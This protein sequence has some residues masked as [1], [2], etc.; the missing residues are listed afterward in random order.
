MKPPWWKSAV[1]YQIY[2]R[3][4]ADAS[5]DGIGDLGGVRERLDHLAWLGVDALW[6]SPIYPSPMADFGYDVA[7]YC[8]VHPLFGSLAEFDAL[9]AAAHARGI[10]VLL[11]FVGAH[12]SH[13]HP[14][15]RESR[16]SRTSPKRGWYVWRDA[17]PDGSLP[18]NWRAAF[19]ELPAWTLDEKTGQYYL[20]SFLPEQPDLDWSN[21]E[22]VGAMHGALRFWLDRGVDGFR[23][24]VIHNIGK[25]PALPDVPPERERLPHHLL[26]DDPL[27]LELLRRMRRLLDSYPGERV[28]V[29]EVVLLSTQAIARH[30]GLRDGLH[31]AFNFLPLFAPWDAA[32]WRKRIES[33]SLELDP[34]DAW[35]TWVLSNH[36]N[37]RHATRY[38]SEARARASAFLLLGLRGTPF[39]YQGEELGL[40][41]AAIPESRRVDPG[42]RDGCRA[43]LP[44]DGKPPLHGWPADPWLPFPPDA[45]R[46][47]VQSLRSDPSSIL[48]LYRRLLSARR[49]SPA[50]SVGAQTLL[51]APDGVVAWRRELEGDVRWVAVNFTGEERKIFLERVCSVEVASD[52]AGEGEV[53]SGSLRPDQALLLRR[54]RS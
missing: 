8:D 9:V 52:G 7:D 27:T 26:N 44:W 32:Q 19:L 47:N 12:T 34:I 28:M 39:L 23:A 4:F 41:D 38:G 48:H 46:R 49:A 53:F 29:G 14:W 1:V 31:L 6:L 51:D 25:D 20:H 54:S 15:F 22:V 13:E 45:D 50:L 42:N 16:A 5:G 10:R 35:P 24:D 2:P 33:V 40:E 37:P 43:P 36:D 21:P 30:Y 18:N 17:R 3:S 11:D